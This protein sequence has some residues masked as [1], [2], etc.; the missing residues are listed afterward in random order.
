MGVSPISFTRRL[1]YALERM[2]NEPFTVCQLLSDIHQSPLNID[3]PNHAWTIDELRKYQRTSIY[4]PLSRSRKSITISPLQAPI[5]GP[6]LNFSAK[7]NFVILSIMTEGDALFVIDHWKSWILEQLPLEAKSLS[8]IKLIGAFK[9][10]STLLIVQVPMAVWTLLPERKA[11]KFVDFVSSE[12]LLKDVKGVKE[13]EAK[14]I[15]RQILSS[16]QIILT[17]Y[18]F[19]YHFSRLSLHIP[20]SRCAVPFSSFLRPNFLDL[21][22]SGLMKVPPNSCIYLRTTVS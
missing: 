21:S 14:V 12:N 2:S 17:L 18:H 15:T 6:Q 8:G 22:Y 5:L 13:G 9:R 11:Y 4:H 10:Q 16:R 19:S 3:Y 20:H 7:N 1:I